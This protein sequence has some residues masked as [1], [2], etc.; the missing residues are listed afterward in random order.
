M[1]KHT[2]HQHKTAARHSGPAPAHHA[3]KAAP[4]TKTPAKKALAPVVTMMLEPQ[5][6]VIEVMELDFVDPDITL[7]EEALVTDFED[8]DL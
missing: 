4:M 8:E 5:P 7:D 1:S 6:R 2:V 3:V